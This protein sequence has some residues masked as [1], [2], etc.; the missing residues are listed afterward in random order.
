M[1]R[2]KCEEI[3]DRLFDIYYDT[4]RFLFSNYKTLKENRLLVA[5]IE[6][7]IRI[8]II[9][10]KYLSNEFTFKTSI[11]L[12]DDFNNDVITIGSNNMDKEWLVSKILSKEEFLFNKQIGLLL[13]NYNLVQN[14]VYSYLG[15]N[16]ID[17]DLIVRDGFTYMNLFDYINNVLYNLEKAYP[18]DYYRGDNVINLP[19][20]TIRGDGLIRYSYID[21]YYTSPYTSDYLDNVDIDRMIANMSLKSL[22]SL[23]KLLKEC[24]LILAKYEENIKPKEMEIEL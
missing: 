12:L 10:Q 2:E 17:K 14:Y 5:N 11:T 3:V 4:N 16:L 20:L 8:K 6:R 23:N 18:N 15:N 19:E 9:T 22:D 1:N 21:E 13:N 7:Y 24:P